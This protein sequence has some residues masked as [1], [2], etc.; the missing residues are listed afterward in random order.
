MKIIV[1]TYPFKE[2]SSYIKELKDMEHQV[3][4]N[5]YK[6]KMSPTEVKS[7]MEKE[8]PDIIIA[9]TEKYDS[10]LL[11]TCTNLKMISRVGIGMD[12]VDLEE[13]EKRGI[14]VTNTP[15]AP[16]NAVAEL[17]IGQ[18][19][20]SLRR[21]E[22]I[23][24]DLKNGGWDRHIGKELKN[25]KV[26][27]IGCGRIGKSV[28]KKLKG[29]DVKEILMYDIDQTTYSHIENTTISDK[30]NILKECDIISIHIPYNDDNHDYITSKEF[31]LMRNGSILINMSR[32]GIINENNLY[33]WLYNNEDSYA[34]ID[35]FEK[36]PYGGNLTNLVNI[37]LTPHL[38]SCSMKS[39]EEMEFH[40][41]KNV[42]EYLENES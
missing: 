28:I 2:D 31:S 30:N 9:G 24:N 6:R 8:N 38:G 15:D 4:F 17:T 41:V 23:S 10:D 29:F 22:Q 11:D 36:E 21:V 19:I 33:N 3:S 27:I 16:T 12:S 7:L 1:T 40:S 35:V 34:C 5:P 42:I 13:T 26:G 18:M 39:R 32:G 25:S 37:S 14:Y 20:N